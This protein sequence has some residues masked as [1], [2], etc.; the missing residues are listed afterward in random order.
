[1]GSATSW[2]HRGTE[3][4]QENQRRATGD[5]TELHPINH[6][7]ERDCPADI[8]E[9]ERTPYGCRA[10]WSD[11]ELTEMDALIW[12]PKGNARK[13]PVPF[14]AFFQRRLGGCVPSAG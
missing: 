4:Q 13:E 5:P 1:M 3:A 10:D 12:R 6:H 14:G 8:M 11:R 9:P 7:G 2:R